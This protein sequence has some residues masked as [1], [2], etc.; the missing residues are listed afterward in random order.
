MKNTALPPGMTLK[1]LLGPSAFIGTL[2]VKSV[3]I[4]KKVDWQKLGRTISEF[5]V[6]SKLVQVSQF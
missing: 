4:A 1:A 2:K 6:T 5:K 3:P